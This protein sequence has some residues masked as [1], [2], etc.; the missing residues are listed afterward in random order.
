MT[1]LEPPPQ[2]IRLDAVDAVSVITLADPAVG[3]GLDPFVMEAEI[4]D[5]LRLFNHDRTT[6]AIVVTGEGPEFCIGA[7]HHV[8]ASP[9]YPQD[10]DVSAT[11]RLAHGYAYGVIWE[12]LAEVNKP[13]IAA[14]RGRCA[15]GGFGLA[16][17]ADLI[18]AGH[19][20]TFVT[21]DVERGRSPFSPIATILASTIG[22]H[23]ALQMLWLGDELDAAGAH[24]LGLVHSVV[25]DLACDDVALAIAGDLAS[26]PPVSVSLA[27]HLV[28]KAAAD[29][30]DYPLTRALAYHTIK[31]N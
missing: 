24:A 1:T 9:R 7:H 3:N 31:P 21:T 22:K 5:A 13:L 17:A 8:D 23:R 25:D 11:E 30:R 19:S 6:R 15:D 29:M 2:R 18:V 4:A 28:R 14:V 10:V 12:A 16:L 26:R 20:A 27:R